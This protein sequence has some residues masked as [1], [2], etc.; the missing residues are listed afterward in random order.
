MRTLKKYKEILGLR[1]D[2]GMIAGIL[3]FDDFVAQTQGHPAS[4]NLRLTDQLG[5]AHIST[6]ASR[7][8]QVASRKC[9]ASVK[10][11]GFF[12]LEDLVVVRDMQEIFKRYA[13][14]MQECK[15]RKPAIHNLKQ[16]AKVP[17]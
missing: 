6:V 7:K 13:R 2:Y 9:Q 1:N 17:H 15:K 4:S 12:R 14:H 11:V 5:F 16:R 3:M 10:Q 8:S